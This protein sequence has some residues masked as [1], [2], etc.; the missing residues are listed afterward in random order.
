MAI[1]YSIGRDRGQ[2]AEL[3]QLE[4]RLGGFVDQNPLFL[5]AFALVHAESDQ[6]DDARRLLTTLHQQG[7]WPRN[8]LWLGTMVAALEASVL[9]GE[10]EL[11]RRYSA[12]LTRYSGQWALAG[13][14]LACWGPVD[15]V[16]GLAHAAFGR[17]DDAHAMLTS[18][19]QAAT[20]QGAAP[21]V[22]RCAAGLDGLAASS[23]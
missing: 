11:I 8:W 10:H 6:F 5:A 15:R 9:A 22:V 18:A 17:L 20:A 21:W 19:L 16:L 2:Q 14:E 12:V 4:H 13:A 23:S 3:A 7:P 1:T